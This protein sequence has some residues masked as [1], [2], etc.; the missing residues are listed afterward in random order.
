MT[1]LSYIAPPVDVALIK[2][3]LTTNVFI[4]RTGKFNNEIY[5]VNVHNAPN[6]VRE[7]GDWELTFASAD[8]GTGKK[9]I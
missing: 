7:V 3:E 8:G 1:D 6:T 2:K 9:L 4:R 5:I